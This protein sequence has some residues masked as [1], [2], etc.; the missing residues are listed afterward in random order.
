[1]IL[2]APSPSGLQHVGRAQVKRVSYIS[3]TSSSVCDG[4]MALSP[5][6]PILYAASL[7]GE[8]G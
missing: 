1:M 5:Y 4:I 8:L 6:I 7:V 2:T 3:V